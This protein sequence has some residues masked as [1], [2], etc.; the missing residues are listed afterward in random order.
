MSCLD[1]LISKFEGKQHHKIIFQ[2]S[3]LSNVIFKILL[4]YGQKADKKF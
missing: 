1:R 4:K 2:M 3:V